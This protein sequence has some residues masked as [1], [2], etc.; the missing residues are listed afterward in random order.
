MS[1][2]SVKIVWVVT[3][4]FNDWDSFSYLLKDLMRMADGIPGYRFFYL[5]V[6]DASSIPPP[7]EGLSCPFTLLKLRRN[8]GHQRAISV[9]L[10]WLHEYHKEADCTIV[11]DAD[12]EDDPAAIP[13]ILA[14]YEKNGKQIVFASRK[15][16]MESAAFRMAYFWYKLFFRVLT[17]HRISFGNYSLVPASLLS[18]VVNVSEIWNHYSGGIMKA[19]LPLATVP[20]DRKQ[21]YS[22]KSRMNTQSLVLHGLRSVSVY[23]D[24]V[25]AR[26]ILFFL[27]LAA[28]FGL[29]ILAVLYFR[30]FTDLAIPGWATTALSGLLILL[31]QAL[32]GTLFLTFVVLAQNT[33]RLV[34]PAIHYKDYLDAVENLPSETTSQS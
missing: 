29:G 11:M 6:D 5:A 15:K 21:R 1:P 9:G 22:G 18:A 7:R 32:I 24:R 16:R 12:G 27:A 28:L 10:S 23:L 8:L 17:G 14:E 4:V 20:F 25:A 13:A 34:I 26:L 31:F 3:P 19:G 2:S 33:Q 30:Y